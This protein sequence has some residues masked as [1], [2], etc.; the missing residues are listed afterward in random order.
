MRVQNISDKDYKAIEDCAKKIVDQKQAFQRLILTKQEAL[1]LFKANPFK[2]QLIAGKIADDMKVTA[3][4][5]GDL[6]D[7]CT[8][9]HIPST[10]IIKAFKIMKNSAAYWLGKATNDSLNRVYGISFPSKKEMDEYIHLKE[11]AERRDHRL[12]GKQQKLFDIHELSPGCAFFYPHGT[13]I[14]NKLMGLIREQ[15]RVRGF[16][17]VISPNIFNLKLWKTSGHYDK[18]KENLFLLKIEQQGFGVKPMNC[19]GHCLMFDNEIRSYR[20]LPIRL[21]D[22]G[23]LH[24]NEISGALSGLTRVRRFQQDDAHIFCAP[25]QLSDEVMSSLDFL[26]H[27]YGIFGFTFELH[28]STRPETRLGSDELWDTAE[29]ALEDALNRFGKPWSLNPGDGAFYGPKID[30]KVYDALKRPHQCGTIQCDF[31]LPIRFNLQ[32]QSEDAAQLQKEH[33]AKK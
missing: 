22:F 19:P 15:Y 6:I 32:Y 2:L 24:R 10:K 12:I 16:Q 33:A 13:H 3:Y 1:E 8:G 27:I 14:Y 4:K 11:E 23:V 30:I 5:C 28:L 17:E 26:N 20:E 29:K 25:E 21:A 9:P 18:Y 31:Q 7:L